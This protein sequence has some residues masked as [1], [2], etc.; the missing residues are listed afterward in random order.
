MDFVWSGVDK[1]NVVP[2]GSRPPLCFA[3]PFPNRAA[4]ILGPLHDCHATT[5]KPDMRKIEPAAS[6]CISI[7]GIE[8]SREAIHDLAGSLHCG[9]N[10]LVVHARA[11]DA[12]H[13]Q[14][15]PGPVQVTR[16]PVAPAGRRPVLPAWL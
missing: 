10:C 5:V 12:C 1:L 13:R 2:G 6:H 16:C 8:R 14:F 9:V 11:S 4:K 7:F 3:S 15:T